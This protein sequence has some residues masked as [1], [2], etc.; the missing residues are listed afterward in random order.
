M[1]S[2][3]FTRVQRVRVR[4]FVF[5]KAVC[6]RVDKQGGR[7]DIESVR[8]I[9]RTKTGLS[10]LLTSGEGVDIDLASMPDA[11]GDKFA[12][13]FIRVVTRRGDTF[14]LVGMLLF[15]CVMAV[16]AYVYGE[17]RGT[18]AVGAMYE[19][20]MS[21]LIQRAGQVNTMLH[22]NPAIQNLLKQK[23]SPAATSAGG[24][25]QPSIPANLTPP[26]N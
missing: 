20:Q 2:Q 7:I 23:S 24:Q 15:S 25:P 22:N 18:E 3:A 12:D 9:L 8:H 21:A 6:W 4:L 13:R 19:K 17:I 26:T 16:A 14:G 1:G 10:V 5:R 11:A